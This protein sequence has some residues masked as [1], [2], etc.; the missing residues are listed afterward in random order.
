MKVINN[1][2]LL[3]ISARAAGLTGDC[4]PFRKSQRAGDRALLL[5]AQTF[6]TAISAISN[7]PGGCYDESLVR[8][9]AASSLCGLGPAAA[10]AVNLGTAAP[11]AVLGAS[12]V[13]NTGN[14]V[15][16]G[17]LGVSAG[18]AITGFL[19]G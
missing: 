10:S 16:N 18:T 19:Q 3:T 13:T 5:R 9:A 4:P 1:S 17:D 6:F 8:L 2:C 11:F 14:S 15:I 7:F 12:T